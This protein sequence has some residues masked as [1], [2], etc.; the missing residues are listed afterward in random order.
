MSEGKSKTANGLK[1]AIL[2]VILGGVAGA[3]IWCFLK[4]VGACAALYRSTIPSDGSVSYIPALI[5]MA[6]G[7]IVGI[8]HRKY[9][10][11]PETLSVVIT[12]IKKDKYYDYRPIIPMLICAFIPLACLASVGPEAGLTG[13]IAALCYWVGDNVTF[14]KECSAEF[15][16][17]G[18]AVT[19]GQLFH[20]PLFG[21]FA[22]EEGDD[23]PSVIPALS[24]GQKL[25]YYGL[26][27]VTSF[28]VVEV[29][30]SFFGKAMEGFPSFSEQAVS[31]SDYASA[32]LY[33]PAGFLIYLLYEFFEKVTGS[34]GKH[35][36]VILKETLCGLVIGFAILVVPMAMSS[37]EEEMAKLMESF[38]DYAP[39]ALIALCL[40]KLF[41]TSL[42]INFGMKGGHF[43]PLIFA[44]TCMGF[45]LTG[46]IFAEPAGHAAFA[47]AV[48][49]ATAL[50]AQ[51]K[52]PFA[53]SLLLLLCFPVRL[54][55][56]IF[57]CAAIGSRLGTA[58]TK[59]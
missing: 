3:V 55:L 42:C 59:K 52:K 30:N 26:S 21:I 27:T 51:L 5:C 15:S 8:I 36:P 49:C 19:L 39:V 37:G 14:A 58:L 24:K 35:I 48:V 32:L 29:L 7:L 50:G 17:I 12:K 38:S 54:L 53:V 23:S 10:D 16:E 56:F 6:G 41:M 18:E 28:L 1:T 22:V 47:S 46:F 4:A 40:I 2:T 45:A 9:G 31:G 20:S 44:C 25:L 11:Y 34:A 57:V 33:I 43:F 13:I